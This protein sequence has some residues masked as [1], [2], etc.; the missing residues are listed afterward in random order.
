MSRL[1][2]LLGIALLL[3]GLAWPFLSKLPFGQLP[4]DIL[5]RHKG[6]TFYFPIST[7]LIVSAVIS[8]I[9]WLWKR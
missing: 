9:L 5:I 8:L 3:L 2:I 6:F 4:G 7:C 1:L